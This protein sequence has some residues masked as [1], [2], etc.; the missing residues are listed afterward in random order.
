MR[1]Y[2]SLLLIFLTGLVLRIAA[3]G[4][5]HTQ[6][7]STDEAEYIGIARMLVEQGEFIDSN[8]ELAKRSPLFPF[9]LSYLF[10]LF[11]SGL[12]IPQVIGCFISSFA[13]YLVY[14]LSFRLWNNHQAALIASSAVAFYPGLIFCAGILQT[15][16]VYI[17]FFLLAF[18]LAIQLTQSASITTAVLLGLVSALAA[19]TRAVF[20]GF[21]PILLLMIWYVGWKNSLS[22]T[23][24]IIVAFIIWCL[25]LSPWIT[26][27]YKIFDA[28]VPISSWG[29]SS[30]IIGNN[31]YATGTWRVKEGYD[32]WYNEQAIKRGINNLS[33]LNEVEKNSL[34][35]DIAIEWMRSNPGK[36]IELAFKKAHMFSVYP[37]TH[38]DRII[39]IQLI[40][41]IID[42]LLLIGVILG[43]F[44]APKSQK[45]TLLI[46][47]AVL[48]FFLLQVILHAEARYRLPLIPLISIFFGWGMIPLFDKQ[49]R[50]F[51]RSSK[52]KITTAGILI[53]FVIIIY[54]G[55]GI[56]FLTGLIK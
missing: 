51:F 20:F 35:K 19:L 30:L 23:R 55:T 53:G 1:K 56:M 38:T 44:I 41:V 7:Y 3:I 15:E 18:I 16:N 17:V 42:F 43:I 25:F 29:G 14:V 36:I 26:R 4:P 22:I 39:W 8:G 37:A 9:F 12:L 28:F 6:A 27:N 21:F 2:K 5:V 34:S 45:R 40:A 50:E 24:Y 49:Q 13:I 10:R 48:F 32:K 52:R 31:P 54:T 46:A 11:G 47:C 33:E